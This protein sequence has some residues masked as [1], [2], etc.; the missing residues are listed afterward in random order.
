MIID[1]IADKQNRF[2]LREFKKS[3][4]KE[5]LRIKEELF[6][7]ILYHVFGGAE[8]FLEEALNTQKLNPRLD[9]YFAIAHPAEDYVIGCIGVY[10]YDNGSVELGYFL[11]PRFQGKGIIR[12]AIAMSFMALDNLKISKVWATVDPENDASLKV[13]KDFGFKMTGMMEN[14]RKLGDPRNPAHYNERGELAVRPRLSFELDMDTLK[15]NMMAIH[16]MS[17]RG[18]VTHSY[19]HH[20]Q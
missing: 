17:F 10:G 7:T 18:T 19:N 4:L 20:T 12:S 3:D 6:I 13:M 2:A 11:S 8:G 15:K 5:L 9:Y 16:Q 1:R 14:S